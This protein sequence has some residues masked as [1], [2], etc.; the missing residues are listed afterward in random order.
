MSY[1][2]LDSIQWGGTPKI[3][4]SFGY[5]S[6]R[7]GG[8]MQYRIYVTVA[9]LT[10]A[11]YFGYPIYL[12][13]YV[14]GDCVDSGY[15]LK[16]A[17]PSRWS[18]SIEYDSGWVTAAGAM[19]SAPLSIRLYS[20][21]GSTRD[22]SYGYA[23]PVERVES[24]GD[25]TLTAG[26]A[27][28]GQ[29]GTLTVT[30]PGYGYSFAFRY[31]LG[32]AGGSIAAGDLKTVN[33]SSGR[34]VYQWTVPEALAQ[35]LP[36]S[37]WGTGTVTMQ[38]YSGGTLVGSLSAPFTAYVPETMRPEV[39]LETAV[40]NDNA[41]V[42]GWGVCL[43]GVSRMQYTAEATAMG[44]ASVQEYRFR[45]AGQEITGASGTTGAVGISGT[46]TPVVTVT[47]S[48]GRT[49]AAAHIGADT[50]G[51]CAG[52]QQRHDGRRAGADRGLPQRRGRRSRPPYP[53]PDGAVAGAPDGKDRPVPAHPAGLPAH[54][55]GHVSRYRQAGHSRRDTQQARQ[56]DGGGI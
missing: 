52:A 33:S 31:A 7:S 34:V 15:T 38:V 54:C 41:A 56:A 55:G 14:D 1:T 3:G 17:S 8:D 20:G 19:G 2:A 23:L 35:Q 26:D 10:G 30:R 37:T 27:V 29:A 22:D 18:G 36:E 9:P 51:A 48:R 11:S 13:V 32:S 45:F 6:R 12:T 42:Q 4:V 53:P 39:T 46:L 44:G 21:S 50:A 16:Q 25:F 5:D 49:P 47:D 40:V 43:Q 24:I 28:I